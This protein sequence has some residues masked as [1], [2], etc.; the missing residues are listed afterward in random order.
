MRVIILIAKVRPTSPTAWGA[1]VLFAIVCIRALSLNHNFSFLSVG[2]KESK[3]GAVALVH[4]IVCCNVYTFY[5]AGVSNKF[6]ND[7]TYP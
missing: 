6:Q 3:N 1:A 4:S 5:S 2:I 7:Q